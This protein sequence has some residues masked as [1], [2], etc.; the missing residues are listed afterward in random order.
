MNRIPKNLSALRLHDWLE[1]DEI[2]PLI[3]DVR[4]DNELEIA[5]FPFDFI[6]LP[7]SKFS[8]WMNHWSDDIARTQ[9]VVIVCHSGIRSFR[10]G[11]WL[12]DNEWEGE[13]WNLEGGIDAWSVNIDS[14]IPRY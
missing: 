5:C 1:G 10:F 2:S 13:V 11:S 9:K 4:E 14:D 7:L 6:H 8:D 12:I 3:I